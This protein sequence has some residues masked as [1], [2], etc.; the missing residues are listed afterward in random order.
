MPGNRHPHIFESLY[1]DFRRKQAA[2][3]ERKRAVENQILLQSQKSK[4]NNFS[5]KLIAKK[6]IADIRS[7]IS[8]FM[9]EQK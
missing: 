6:A 3:L 9:D 4:M 8:L 7:V 5:S 2:S 1:S